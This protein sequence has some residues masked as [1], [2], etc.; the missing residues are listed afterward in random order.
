MGGRQQGYLHAPSAL[1]SR[2]CC[3]PA[4]EVG[5][6]VGACSSSCC[7]TRPPAGVLP[8]R[9]QLPVPL[10]DQRIRVVTLLLLILSRGPR[11]P[12]RSL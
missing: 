6:H 1:P 9:F 7:R 3:Q 4:V 10:I 8:K 2:R 5:S 12:S 11:L